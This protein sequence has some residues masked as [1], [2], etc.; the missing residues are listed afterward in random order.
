MSDYIHINEIVNRA[1]IDLQISSSDFDLRMQ[2]WADEGVRKMNTLSSYQEFCETIDVIDGKAKLPCGYYKL[3]GARP[4]SDGCYC[5]NL[6]YVDTDVCNNY[7][8]TIGSSMIFPHC[9]HYEDI[10][11]IIG[12]YIHFHYPSDATQ[13][14]LAW[15]GLMTDDDGLMIIHTSYEI[16]LY[17]Y[18]CYKVGMSPKYPMD[19]D[20]RDDYRKAWADESSNV[21]GRDNEKQWHL[22][23]EWIGVALLNRVKITE[24]F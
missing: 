11:K 18:L 20:V 17:N 9:C 5:N 24:K 13:L 23:K 10:F 12:G 4:I 2:L 19:K 14:Q 8:R 1:K 21:R 6:T 15:L 3:L 16:P 7:C 22:E